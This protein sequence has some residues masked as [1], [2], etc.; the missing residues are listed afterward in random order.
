MCEISMVFINCRA[1][2]DRIKRTLLEGSRNPT[3]HVRRLS[4]V[5]KNEFRQNLWNLAY[6]CIFVLLSRAGASNMGR[7]I[8]WPLKNRRY[9]S[10]LLRCMCEKSDYFQSCKW[11]FF[12]MIDLGCTG[13]SED[14]VCCVSFVWLHSRICG[15]SGAPGVDSRRQSWNSSSFSLG[16]SW[17]L[18]GY[19]K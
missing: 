2:I 3:P 11:W 16:I 4:S 5:V 9:L 19:L 13:V 15:D 6:L 14:A 7:R 10:V 18:S 12:A 1:Q 8:S 17:L